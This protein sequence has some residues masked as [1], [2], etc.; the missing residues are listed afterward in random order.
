MAFPQHTLLKK[1]KKEAKSKFGRGIILHPKSFT[2]L[3][4]DRQLISLFV[5]ALYGQKWS[6]PNTQ[7]T[8]RKK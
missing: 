8:R 2:Q 3:L 6:F 5:R 1:R 4:D 7:L